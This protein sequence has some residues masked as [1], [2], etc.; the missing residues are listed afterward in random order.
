MGGSIMTASM[1]GKL[2]IAGVIGAV[3]GAAVVATAAPEFNTRGNR[4]VQ[5][6]SAQPPDGGAVEAVRRLPALQG[7]DAAQA[8]GNRHHADGALLGRPIRVVLAPPAGP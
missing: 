1:V 7:A 2:V 5:H 3:V 4:S 6:L 8:Q